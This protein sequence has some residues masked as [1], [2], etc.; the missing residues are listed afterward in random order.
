MTPPRAPGQMW[1]EWKDAVRASRAFLRADR[2]LATILILAIPALLVVWLV[3]VALGA[4][5]LF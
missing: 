3:A 2:A 4:T 1:D 5:P